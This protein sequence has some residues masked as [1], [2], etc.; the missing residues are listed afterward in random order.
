MPSARCSITS[1]RRLAAGICLSYAVWGSIGCGEAEPNLHQPGPRE[2]TAQLEP[3]EGHK[4]LGVVRFASEQKG[5]S[6][7]AEV[8]ALPGE[9]HAFHVH[10]FGICDAPDASSAG[11]HF[12]FEPP[13]SPPQKITGNLGELVPD[14]AGRATYTT[15]IPTV[16]LRELIGRS[17]IVHERSNN[18]NHP[19]DGNAGAR[20]ACGVIRATPALSEEAAERGD[21]P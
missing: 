17:V 18:A 7:T 14:E 1:R 4:A 12:P 20:I 19:P 11:P 3:T 6:V 21:S 5:V 8:S 13:R 10:E 16:E 2:A 9:A 15:A